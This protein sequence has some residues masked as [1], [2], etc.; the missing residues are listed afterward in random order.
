MLVGLSF[1]IRMSFLSPIFNHLSPKLKI[2]SLFSS[3]LCPVPLSLTKPIPMIHT[4][5]YNFIHHYT[6][7]WACMDLLRPPLLVQPRTTLA[8]STS[9]IFA[10]STSIPLIASKVVSSPPMSNLSLEP[11]VYS[12]PFHMPLGAHA[13]SYHYFICVAIRSL[14]VMQ[15]QAIYTL[16]AT[17]VHKLAF[18]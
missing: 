10:S 7:H 15:E 11:L 2:F 4:L 6:I 16:G 5:F 1:S 14:Q 17:L 3:K 12:H 9:T 18:H 13:S 8:S